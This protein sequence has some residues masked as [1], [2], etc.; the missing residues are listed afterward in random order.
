MANPALIIDHLVVADTDVVRE[1]QRWTTGD[2]GEV[3][4][5]AEV[6]AK[7]DLTEFARRSL[8]IGAQALSVGRAG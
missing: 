3:V 8:S 4:T 5:D 1:A 6:L 7:A 2:R